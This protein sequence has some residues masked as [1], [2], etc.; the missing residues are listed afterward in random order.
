MASQSCRGRVVRRLVP[1]LVV[2]LAGCSGGRS[3]SPGSGGTDVGHSGGA[4]GTISSDGG[5]G[6]SVGSGGIQGS[7]GSPGHVDQG[8]GTS[9]TLS[10]SPEDQAERARINTAL[11]AVS[12]L[13]SAGLATRY[14]AGFAPGLSYDP[15]SAANLPLIRASHLGLTAAEEQVLKRDGF[16][17]SDRM[18]FPGFTYGYNSIYAD[19]LPLFVS[20]DSILN[21]VHRSYDAILAAVET[22]SLRPTLRALLEGM[23]AKISAGALASF[24][25]DTVKD[26]DLYLAVPLGL[27]TGTA[28]TPVAGASTTEIANLLGL[29]NAATGTATISLFGVNRENEDFSQFKPRGHYTDSADLGTYFKAMMWL[30]RIDFRMIETQPDGTQTFRR[31]Q[32]DGALALSTVVNGDDALVAKWQQIAR[33]LDAFVGE[34]DSMQVTDFS[35][36]LARLSA[37]NAGAVAAIADNDVAAAIIAGNFGSQR[38]A[39]RIM[40]APPHNQPLPLDRSFLLLGQRYVIDSHVFSNVV[41]DRIPTS[42]LMPDPLDVAFAVFANNQAA[43]MLKPQIDTFTYAPALGAMRVLADDHGETFWNENLYNTWLG[44]LRALSPAAGGQ[45]G[46]LEIAATEPWARRILNTQLASWA[47][48]RHDTILYAK[49]SYTGGTTCSYPDALVEPSPDFFDRLGRFAAKGQEVTAGL[50]DTVGLLPRIRPYFDNLASVAAT[51]GNMAREQ[52]SGT[53]FSDAEMAFINQT[54]KIQ[55]VGCG[56]SVG[57]GWYPKLFF[58]DSSTTFRP[59][60][61][62]VHTQPTDESGNDVG[63]VLHVG[64][65]YARLMIVTANTCTGPRAYAGLASSY[66]EKI[67]E[68]YVRLDDPTWESQLGSKV[69]T[70]PPADPPWTTDFIVHP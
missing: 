31:R 2:V 58:D 49:Q 24:G 54:V 25:T 22:G 23:R 20:A 44:S 36:L 68:H 48:L 69:S 11:S 64:T 43:A 16:V 21:A 50:T 32:F 59:T 53:P 34:P 52:L 39:S 8:P 12:G 62:D 1:V 57:V 10:P 5:S 18:K 47:E 63:R 41:Y 61:A 56:S 51:L 37:S 9:V 29:A 6:P 30:G 67:T 7:G 33:L 45:N 65:G 17:I 55:T 13:D 15:L 60:I 46:P 3:G 19:D 40:L 14:P 38:I 66:F 28:P 35:A 42:R 70:T 27:L 4:G 26:I